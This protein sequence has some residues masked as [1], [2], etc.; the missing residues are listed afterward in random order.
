MTRREFVNACLAAKIGSPYMPTRRRVGAASGSN[1]GP[2]GGG[3]QVPNG[4]VSDPIRA[5]QGPGLACRNEEDD[6]HTA[7]AAVTTEL[8]Y[9]EVVRRSFF[10]ITFPLTTGPGTIAASIALGADAPR[11]PLLYVTNAVVATSSVD[12]LV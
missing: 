1:W 12:E 9:T 10:P 5:L 8:P 7:A 2:K 11:S 4:P 3:P 6:V